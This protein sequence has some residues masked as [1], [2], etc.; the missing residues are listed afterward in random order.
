VPRFAVDPE[1][2]RSAGGRQSSLGDALLEAC[3][4][5][6]GAGATAAGAAGDGR[7]AGAVEAMAGGWATSLAE[8]GGAVTALAT[9][10]NAAA[11]AYE[12]TDQQAVPGPR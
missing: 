5:L 6:E 2:L 9:N 3:G 7:V 4:Q 10:V 12:G 8:L 1:Q 11:S